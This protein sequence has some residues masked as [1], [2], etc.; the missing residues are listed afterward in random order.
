MQ[1]Y[2]YEKTGFSSSA[3]I[4]CDTH[5]R[6]SS[7]PRTIARSLAFWLSSLSEWLFFSVTGSL[8][9]YMLSIEK[10]ISFASRATESL[11]IAS[12][13]QFSSRKT[14]LFLLF[15]HRHRP[16]APQLPM[17]RK[18]CRFMLRPESAPA[19]TRKW[20]KICNWINNFS[21]CNSPLFFVVR[22][23]WN[24]YNTRRWLF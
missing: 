22:L 14:R 15:L 18:T 1:C 7:A 11:V 9:L 13:G 2:V 16:A 19:A 24:P 5:G 6:E 21:L 12:E 17:R 3:H 10:K 20:N 23:H 8:S 4:E